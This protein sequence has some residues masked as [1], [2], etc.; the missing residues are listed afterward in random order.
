MRKAFFIAIVFAWIAQPVMGQPNE[1][2]LK[3]LQ[4]G[5]AKLDA[6]PE[7]PSDL[8]EEYF[9]SIEEKDKKVGW[10]QIRLDTI[11]KRGETYYRYRARYGIDSISF[12]L[13]EGEMTV[14]LDRKLTPV[15][16]N[17]E[18][19]YIHPSTGK[20]QI[21]DRARI[22]RNA[23]RR[24]V[25]DGRQ[26]IKRKF[27]LEN[28]RVSMLVEPLIGKL[29]FEEG[30]K[31]AFLDYDILLGRFRTLICEVKGKEDGKLKVTLENRQLVDDPNAAKQIEIESPP[32]AI[33]EDEE[34]TGRGE[35]KP[36]YYLYVDENEKVPFISDPVY[37]LDFKLSD[38]QEV[39][40]IRKE[41]V[42]KP[43]D[44]PAT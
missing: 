36:E 31:V 41:L 4:K 5:Y 32:V 17:N 27:N 15:D 40:E 42:V 8:K 39:D 22:K 30:E 19:S 12:G 23:F 44:L 16:L 26:T 3:L 24:R 7:I 38:S 20:R 1:E 13:A 11:T 2:T 34:G 28:T 18:M 6:L 37:K 33:P 29:K 10:K 43:D 9:Y 21:T 14:I 25:F 35:K